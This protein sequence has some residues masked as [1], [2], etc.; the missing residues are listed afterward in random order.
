MDA[1][2]A[3]RRGARMHG[4]MTVEVGRSLAKAFEEDGKLGGLGVF[5]DH[6]CSGSVQPTVYMGRRY[7]SDA[8]LSGLDIVVASDRHVTVAVEIEE[9]PSRPKV[10]VGDIF[11]V[12]LA[13]SLMI[14]G[15]RYSLRDVELIVAVVTS[16]KGKRADKLVRLER[17]VNKY[18]RVL[19][20][21]GRSR[22]IRAVRIVPTSPDDLVRRVDR[23]IRRTVGKGLARKRERDHGP[24]GKVQREEIL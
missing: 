3:L 8:A 21:S 23:L 19:R 14:R 15:Q 20:D 10:I 18:I 22:S 17:H 11:A 24:A 5:Y 1:N 6:D 4:K 7:G 13:D 9:R 16:E 2:E 12:A